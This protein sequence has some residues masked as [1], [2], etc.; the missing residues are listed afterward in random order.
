[1]AIHV[2]VL[3]IIIDETMSLSAPSSLVIGWRAGR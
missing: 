1:M 3:P 2:F